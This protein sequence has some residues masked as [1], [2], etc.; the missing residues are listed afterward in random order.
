MILIGLTGTTGAGKGEVGRIFQSLGACVI[1][2]DRIYHRLLQEDA[3]LRSAL[4]DAFCD[5]TDKNGMIDRKKL[6]PIVFSSPEKLKR[7]NTI[8]HRYVLGETDRLLAEA[9]QN[10]VTVGVIDAP[11][12][13][14]SGA[15]KKCDHVVG[16]I[17]PVTLRKA[18]IMARDGLT[19]AAADARIGG[20]K[21]DDWFRTHCTHIIVNDA[22]PDTLRETAATLYT[23]LTEQKERK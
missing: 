21:S 10:G 9:E 14:E 17:A 23:V 7:L 5:V 2:T 8:T 22:D 15:D 16:V 12:L 20:Q 1:D 4:T 19:A 6:A 13:F 18:R 11:Q 3:S